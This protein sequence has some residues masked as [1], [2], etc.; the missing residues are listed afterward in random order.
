MAEPRDHSDIPSRL[1]SLETAVKGVLQAV[2]DQAESTSKQ[3]AQVFAQI[4][5]IHGKGTPWGTLAAWAVVILS[6]AFAYSEGHV[7]D[8]A[9]VD[10]KAEKNAETMF[11]REY[12]R[13]RSDE[14]IEYIA[15]RIAI[16]KD[17]MKELREFDNEIRGRTGKIEEQV[18]SLDRN[19]FK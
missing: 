13:G 11:A 14:K 6:I 7:R 17:Y 4:N 8:L 19:V 5:Q 16:M 10:A 15:E 1:S 3:F 2:S 18:R 9:R 12:Q